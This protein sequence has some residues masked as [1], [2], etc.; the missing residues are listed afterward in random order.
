MRGA[1][2]R[3]LSGK[4]RVRN[5]PKRF[6]SSL[7]GYTVPLR[8][9]FLWSEF[10]GSN[11]VWYLSINIAALT[12]EYVG[13]FD[14][15]KVKR[16]VIR[17]FPNNNTSATG[18]YATVLLDQNGFGAASSGTEKGWFKT[19]ATMPGS[20]VQHR[21][22]NAI[23]FWK[24]TEAS[25][26]NWWRY[27]NNADYPICT[28]YF[29]DNGQESVELGGVLLVTGHL[30]ARGMY[31]N[32]PTWLRQRAAINS[33]VTADMVLPSTSAPST[34]PSTPSLSNLELE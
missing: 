26:N 10:K 18:I 4:R 6:S 29:A 30:Q 8:K 27:Q 16:L 31:W 34:A 9:S 21:N 20:R 13:T 24:P 19:I 3:K 25:A 23:Y 33:I 22:S 28:L 17:Y 15:F 2:K 14:E 12:K 1:G 7:R 32:A 11:G 5:R